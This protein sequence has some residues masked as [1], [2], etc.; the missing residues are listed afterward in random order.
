MER[1]ALL[2][3][4]R[5]LAQQLVKR[6]VDINEVEKIL[7][8]A[9]RERDLGKTLTIIQRLATLDVLVYSN[10]TKIYAQAIQQIIGPRLQKVDV[11]TGLLLLGW[12]VRFMRYE[13]AQEG[14]TR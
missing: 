10:R 3:D 4:A 9:R 5:V 14:G 8:Y 7:A 12:A 13:A 2:T 6:Q 11:D 1:K